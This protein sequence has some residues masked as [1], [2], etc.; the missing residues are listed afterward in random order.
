M[1]V[2]SDPEIQLCSFRFTL[3]SESRTGSPECHMY[4]CLQL[5][6]M[7]QSAETFLYPILYTVGRD[8]MSM[9]F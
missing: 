8:L 4:M 9:L 7:F 1:R 5:G 2:I 6:F 3:E